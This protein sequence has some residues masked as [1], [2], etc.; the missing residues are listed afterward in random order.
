METYRVTGVVTISVFTD[1]RAIS[2][3]DAF[4]KAGDK[5]MMSLCHQCAS[6]EPA[7]EWVTSGEL[8]GGG[9]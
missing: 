7:T 3:K 5:P 9:C 6:G 1:V 2:R 4:E 8:D